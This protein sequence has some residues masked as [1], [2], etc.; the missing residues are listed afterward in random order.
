MAPHANSSARLQSPSRCGSLLPISITAAMPEGPATSGMAIGTMKGSPSGT[1]PIRPSG[2]GKIM[3][4]PIRKS[5]M[6]PAM[7]TDSCRRCISSSA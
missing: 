4:M 7:A 2:R 6:P 1:A 3:R 5:T